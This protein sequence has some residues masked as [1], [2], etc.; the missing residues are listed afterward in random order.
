MLFINPAHE[1]FGGMLSRYIPV[2]IPVALGTLPAYL[3]KW[4]VQNIRVLDEEIEK[5]SSEN[6]R[7]KLAGLDRPLI[8]GITVLTSQA[9]QEC[10]FYLGLSALILLN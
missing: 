3:K 7:E 8:V 9:A 2:G 4:G 10:F 5:F 6:I 1:R